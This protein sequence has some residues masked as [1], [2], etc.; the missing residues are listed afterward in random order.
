MWFRYQGKYDLMK[1]IGKLSV[2]ILQ[3]NLRSIDVNSLTLTLML[4]VLDPSGPG[5]FGW[6]T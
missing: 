4:T 5:D 2:S 1:R 3:I 6:E